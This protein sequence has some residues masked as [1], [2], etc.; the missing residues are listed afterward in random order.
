MELIRMNHSD[1]LLTALASLSALI[2][3]QISIRIE[4][5]NTLKWITAI[6]SIVLCITAIIKL[7]DLCTEKFPK[8]AKVIATAY[9]AQKTK[10]QS[11][12]NPTK[13]PTP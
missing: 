13:P 2:F 8:W 7:I 9:S 10:F 5:D 11:W 4:E 1:S 12:R 6:S 3:S